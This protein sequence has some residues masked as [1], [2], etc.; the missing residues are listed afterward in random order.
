MQSF[1]TAERSVVLPL[2]LTVPSRY[3]NNRNK[4]PAVFSVRVW[5][6]PVD[7]MTD[8]VNVSRQALSFLKCGILVVTTSNWY[9]KFRNVI[10]APRRSRAPTIERLS[11][12]TVPSAVEIQ[13]EKKMAAQVSPGEFSGFLQ[14]G[15]TDARH[16]KQTETK[17]KPHES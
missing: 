7:G 3:R 15:A 1:L 2:K 6:N 10:R 4:R 17:R 5:E 9:R 13:A 11:S 8:H 16:Y 12:G 14:T